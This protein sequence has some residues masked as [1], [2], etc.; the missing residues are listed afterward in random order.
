M[1]NKKRGEIKIT[2]DK[3]RALKYTLNSLVK[4]ED[5]GID[6]TT[7]ENSAKISDIRAILWVGLIH[8]DKELTIDDVGELVSLDNIQ[9]V[10]KAISEAF[11]SQ[12]KK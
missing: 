5:L 1:A 2:L 9:E 10:T 3:E 4:L 8:E 12:G 6:I 11:G 7:L